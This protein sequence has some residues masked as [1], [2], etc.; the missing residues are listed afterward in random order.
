M[1]A[2]LVIDML[3]D[4]ILPAGRLCIG[5]SGTGIIPFIKEEVRQS[6]LRGEPVIFICDDHRPDD[7]EFLMF[8]PHCIAGSEGAAVIEEIKPHKDEIVIKKR[9]YSGFFATELDLVLREHG[10]S[11]LVLVGVCTNICVLYTAADAR[12]LGYKVTVPT[13]GVASF[14]AEAHEFALKEMKNTLG[15][16]IKGGGQNEP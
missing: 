8:P 3:N 14:D 7:T 6:R 2:L 13:A 4:F 12:N 10:V 16:Q 1:R 11:E 15:I 9:R 5:E